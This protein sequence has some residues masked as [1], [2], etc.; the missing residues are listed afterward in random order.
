MQR[1]WG[2]WSRVGVVIAAAFASRAAWAQDPAAPAPVP[3]SAPSTSAAAPVVTVVTAP[4][5]SPASAPAVAPAPSGTPGPSPNA[6]ASTAAMATSENP[7]P[8]TGRFEFGSY[9]RVRF[10]SDAR[11]G[12]GRQSNIVTHGSRIDEESYAEL[13]LRREDTF[14]DDIHTKVVATLALFPPFFHFS[15]DATQSIALR[16]LY[17]QATYGDWTMWVGSRM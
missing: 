14:K 3:S 7:S 12:T 2:R 11:G 4:P 1:T 13:E 8:D 9:G 15:G 17:A 5:A 6:N 10:A 16:N